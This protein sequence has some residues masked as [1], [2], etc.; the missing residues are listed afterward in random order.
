MRPE[1][2]AI[3]VVAIQ[4]DCSTCR[5]V[6]RRRGAARANQG[7][8]PVVLTL[9]NAPKPLAALLRVNFP[10]INFRDLIAR[11][12]LLG[13]IQLEPCDIAMEQTGRRS[14]WARCLPVLRVGF[15]QVSEAFSSPTPFIAV[16]EPNSLPTLASVVFIRIAEYTQR[17]VAEQARLRSQLESVV[18]VS[19]QGA[20]ARCRIILDA[21]DGMAI[22]VLRKPQAA[23][24]IAER[25]K[26]ASEIGI[27]LS[28]GINHGAIQ[29]IPDDADHP[30]LIGDA[31]G[32]AAS[33]ADFG[34]P[35]YVTTSRAFAEALTEASPLRALSLKKAGTYTDAQV[36][37]H[38]L[39]TTARGTRV[40]RRKL[41]FAIGGTV[42]VALV[43]GAIALRSRQ[44][45]IGIMSRRAGF[46]Q[47]LRWLL[48]RRN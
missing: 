25:C 43:G 27:D 1:L 16:N 21:P 48:H 2:F 19:L 10:A 39:F 7:Q 6:Y 42:T 37:T 34:G 31:I 23:L 5:G 46:T 9:G 20:P 47:R 14:E 36:R 15:P 45:D 44:Q 33:I 41:L 4:D 29:L 35:Q 30:G 8:K 22:A 38:E 11:G 3:H 24:D 13:D 18:A 28:I 17:P 12:R 32:V 26:Y 40:T